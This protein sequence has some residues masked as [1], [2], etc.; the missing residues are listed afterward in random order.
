MKKICYCAFILIFSGIIFGAEKPLKAPSAA[1]ESS[2]FDKLP[3]ELKKIVLKF[4]VEADDF[5]GN[6]FQKLQFAAKN[7][8]HYMMLN[9]RNLDDMAIN[10][11]LIEELARRYGV[12]LSEA[13]MA[14][15]TPGAGKWFA[16]WKA[17]NNIRREGPLL[18]GK[19]QNAVK[20]Y[21]HSANIL[22][23]YI[24]KDILQ[25]VN[26]MLTYFADILNFMVHR[27]ERWGSVSS[28]LLIEAV[29]LGNFQIV[30]RILRTPGLLTKILNEQYHGHD[31]INGTALMYAVKRADLPMV[32]RL[33]QMPDIDVNFQHSLEGLRY[34]YSGKSALKI[35]KSL[36]DDNPNKKA[37]IDA[38]LAKGARE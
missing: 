7:I 24:D 8:R 12:Y 34:S 32:N 9:R 18:L 38:L 33:L 19:T 6:N 3:I 31:D 21:N 1:Q 20:D 15:H 29:K 14:L 4:L 10:G 5:K 27:N 23:R 16:Q 11:S 17:E 25:G 13:T 26:F 2:Y 35:A 37:I 30:D 22:L 28:T 36:P